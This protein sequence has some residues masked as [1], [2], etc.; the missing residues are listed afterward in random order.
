M[1]L[2]GT[3][4][5]AGQSTRLDVAL[6]PERLGGET[7]IVFGFQIAAAH[8]RVPPPL[9]GIDLLYPANIGLVT[10]GLG[11]TTCSTATLELLGPTGC[12]ANAL[13]GYGSALVEIPVGGDVIREPGSITTWMAPVQEGHVALL[14][15]AEGQTPVDAELIFTGQVLEA[16]PPFGGDLQ[17]RIPVIPTFPEAP[18]AA[19]VQMRATIG[20][21]GITY[22]QRAHGHRVPYR[23]A[24][25]RLPRHCPHGG[26]PFAARFTFL[27]GSRSEAR[28]AVPC[29]PA[30]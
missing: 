23:P 19:V 1:V 30:R 25:L 18:D 11:L 14:F 7:T 3:A 13:M 22:Y 4:A 24:G 20:P 17:T 29:P 6:R 9:V 28:A 10:S 27:D 2:A 21:L 16:P 5:A 26:F 15:Y 8:G 12:P